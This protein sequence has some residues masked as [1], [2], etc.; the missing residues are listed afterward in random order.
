LG[1]V[2]SKDGV[3]RFG[4]KLCVP[5]VDDL[6]RDVVV[7]AHQTAYIV[8]PSSSKMYRDLRECY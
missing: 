5:K 4:S 1:F 2:V 3:L 8:H 7:E 6:K